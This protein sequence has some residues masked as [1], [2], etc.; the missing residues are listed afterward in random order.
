MEILK[1][2]PGTGLRKGRAMQL[3]KHQSY[4]SHIYGC[5]TSNYQNVLTTLRWEIHVV[6]YQT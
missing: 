1:R 5:D 3:E 2:R 6:Y 4:Q